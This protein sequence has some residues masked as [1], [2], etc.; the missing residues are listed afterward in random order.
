ML[1]G[2][3]ALSICDLFFR[4]LPDCLSNV[5]QVSND[6]KV[7]TV[8]LLTTQTALL[9]AFLDTY[10]YL[11]GFI[12]VHQVTWAVPVLNGICAGKF[13]TQSKEQTCLEMREFRRRIEQV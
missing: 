3:L 1:R 13:F 9:P 2:F 5:V 4:L 11:W 7:P 12:C 10:S 8:E 6:I